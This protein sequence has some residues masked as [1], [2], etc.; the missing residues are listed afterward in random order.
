[1]DLH[2]WIE[3][4]S[5]LC[6]LFQGCNSLFGIMGEVIS[7]KHNV[8]LYVLTCGIASCLMFNNTSRVQCLIDRVHFCMLWRRLSGRRFLVIIVRLEKMTFK[9]I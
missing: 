4:H 9:I 8:K 6:S 1:M 2:A 3:I 7:Y 5:L